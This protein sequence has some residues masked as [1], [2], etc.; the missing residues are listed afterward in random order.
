MNSRLGPGDV[1]TPKTQAPEGKTRHDPVPVGLIGRNARSSSDSD[2][3]L[4][5]KIGFT[6]FRAV[7]GSQQHWGEG[8]ETP[9]VSTS[10]SR[11]QPPHSRHP[12]RGTFVTT[13]TPL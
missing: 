12:A 8:T 11:A 6:L 1:L 4:F 5:F 7:S 10:R 13:V 9:H 3:L 2:A